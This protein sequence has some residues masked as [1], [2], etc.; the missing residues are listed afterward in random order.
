[1]AAA[2]ED[3]EAASEMNDF[4]QAGLA[5]LNYESAN[6]RFP[7]DVTDL[8]G[9]NNDLSWRVRVL[10]YLEQSKLYE[11]MDL[12]AG[13]TDEANSKFADKMPKILGSGGKLSKMIRI[14]SDVNG[15]GGIT[16]GSSNTIMLIEYP[17]G[18]PISKYSSQYEFII[19]KLGR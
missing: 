10:P 7:F 4:R 1:M 2:E 5:I 8:E 13:P 9:Q 3:A 6:Q 11:Q 19:Q 12:S 14:E 15:F 18:A 16:D 17:E